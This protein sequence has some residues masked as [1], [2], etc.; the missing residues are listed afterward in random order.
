ML[1]GYSGNDF[2]H[3]ETVRL[4]ATTANVTFNNLQRYSDYQHFQIRY[5]ARTIT[6]TDIEQ[7]R[8]QFNAD[9]GSNYSRHELNGVNGGVSSGGAGSQ[10]SGEA[11]WLARNA[12]SDVFSGGV[13]DILDPF[14][15]TKNTTVRSLSGFHFGS[16]FQHMISLSSGAWYDTNSLTEIKLFGFTFNLAAESRFSLYGIKARS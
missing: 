16:G 8:F 7:L 1:A 15:T 10:T 2:H 5:V 4:S 3:L 13:V 9:S 12:S 11:G 6:G 14:E